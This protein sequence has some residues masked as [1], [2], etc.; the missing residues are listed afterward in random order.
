MVS[1]RRAVKKKLLWAM[2]AAAVCAPLAS[3]ALRQRDE[4]RASA[5]MRDALARFDA[6]LEGA[7]APESLDWAGAQRLLDDVARSGAAPD[8]VRRAR[9]VGYACRAL[10]DLARGDLVLAATEVQ[11]ARRESPDDVRVR[12]V[13]G[14]VLQRRG[15]R[16][17]AAQVFEGVARDPATSAPLRVRAGV[18]QLDLLLDEGD[19]HAALSLAEALSREAP[20]SAALENRLGLARASVGDGAGARVAFEEASQA[21]PT[22]PSPLVNLARLARQSGDL[23]RSRTLLEQALVRAPENGDTRL[24][25]AVVLLDLGS[26]DEARAAAREAA[27]YLPEQAGPYVALGE[28]AL[29]GDALADAVAAFRQA[30]DHAPDDASARADLGVALARSGDREGAMRAFAQ[31]TE[32]A[33]SVG[34]AWNGL[35]AMRLALS[36]PEGA[37]GPLQ[38]ASRLLPDDPNPTMNLGLAFERLRRWD[39]AARA[40][41]ET[42][43][44]A[45]TSEAATTHLAAMQ[46]PA[47]HPRTAHPRTTAMR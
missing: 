16:R 25:L 20:R 34:Q 2:S 31:V 14:A 41:R 36:D 47:A 19:G 12:F 30:L 9:A 18:H 43:R 21:A 42:L 22:D 7:V 28:I 6:P 8:D 27:R 38:H 11:S 46:P 4:H 24:A 40:F 37:I 26:L 5:T 3:L 35:G 45:P 17:H 23:A 15:E 33:P 10:G 29:R 32:R 39:D 13:E 1:H 44:R